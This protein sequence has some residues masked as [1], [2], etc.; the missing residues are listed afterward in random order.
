MS[1]EIYNPHPAPTD[2]TIH[3]LL[4]AR[5]SP[6]AIS[7]RAVEVEKLRS[8]LEAARWAPSSFNEQ[9]WSFLVARQED[10]EAYEKMAGCLVEANRAWAGK[11][12][13]LMIAVGTKQ[14]KRNGMPNRHYG[15]DT[16]MALMS[17]CLQATAL[18]LV[19]HMMAGFDG[20]K[21]KLTYKIPEGS[22]ALTA[23]ALGYPGTA[24]DVGALP[25]E[26]RAMEGGRARKG[27]ESIVF[28]GK[29][30]AAAEFLS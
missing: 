9:P 3:A 2:H 1:D 16:G 24:A 15:H 5:Y 13:V 30:G 7:D 11:A 4:G 25:D 14:F 21:A 20:Q 27:L 28:E 29:F 6:R 12:P 22:E 19:T 17:M 18:G 26:L 23:V 10:A 8:V